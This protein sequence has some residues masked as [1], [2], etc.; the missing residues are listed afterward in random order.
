MPED[1]DDQ[2]NDM[3]T[4]SNSYSKPVLFIDMWLLPVHLSWIPLG[5]HQYIHIQRLTD[6]HHPDGIIHLRVFVSSQH[7]GCLRMILILLPDRRCQ[8]GTGG[9]LTVH[10]E[11]SLCRDRHRYMLGFCGRS[12]FG[13]RDFDLD[14]VVGHERRRQQKEDQQQQDNIGQRSLGEERYYPAAADLL[15]RK[16]TRLNSSHVA[17][18]YA[19]FCLKKTT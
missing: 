8:I 14:P 3:D 1:R 16:S 19:V 13:T 9:L 2:K 6:V 5:S 12:R 11:G 7:Q 17:I 4:R 18:S 10:K 15:D